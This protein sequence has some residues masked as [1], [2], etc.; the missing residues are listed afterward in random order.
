[1]AAVPTPAS[2]A[3]SAAAASTAAV[4]TGRG[5]GPARSIS[6]GVVTALVSLVYGLS[7]SA[8]LFSGELAYGLSRGIGSVLVG[9]AVTTLVVALFSSFRFAVAGPD[10]NA[11]AVSAGMLAVLGHELAASVPPDTAVVNVLYML[12]F[13]SC[14][15]GVCLYLLGLLRAGRWIRFV[16]Y[17]VIGGFIASAG[18]LMAVGALRV[19][20]GEQMSFANISI[21][22][23]PPVMYQVAAGVV[24]MIVLWAVLSRITHY[25]ALPVMLLAG[26]IACH[27]LLAAA[28]LDFA[29]ARAAGWLFSVSEGMEFWYPWN[30]SDLALIEWG[31]LGSHLGSM[32]TVVV[33]TTL[34]ILLNATGIELATHI[35][36][37]LD[38][39]LRVE[40]GANVA[41]A[42][43]GGFLGYLSFSRSMINYR[44]GADS[45]LAGVVVALA[46]FLFVLAGIW[47][48]SY[49]PKPILG[50]LLL[51]LGFALCYD[52]AVRSR[53]RI[54]RLD[55]LAILLIFLVILVWNFVS[56]VLVG[57]AVG[58]VMFVAN[59]SRVKVIKHS[60]S[61]AEYRSS[62]ER[63]QD[64][65][66]VLREHG[67]A[68][69]IFVLQSFIFFGMADRL[70]RA[71]MEQA[72]IE[73]AETPRFLVFDFRL[74]HGIDSS[75][76]TSFRKIAFAARAA[77]TRVVATGISAELGR[78][79]GADE[80]T[81]L[82]E[83]R[84]FPDLDRGVEWC[85]SE[86]IAAYPAAVPGED[87]DILPWLTREL[88]DAAQAQELAAY[89]RRRELAADEQLCRQDD[90]ADEM[91]FIERG[92][93]R[94]ELELPGGRRQR[95]RTLGRRTVLGEM[96]LYRDSS[97]S[98]SVYAEQASVVYSLSRESLERMQAE[99]P[100]LAA[101]FN[102]AIVRTL[103]NRLA[104]A[105]SL[106]AALQR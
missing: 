101:L 91:Y 14:V 7:F 40:G 75:A 61:G 44:M 98:A 12:A 30:A 38:R 31:V 16:P 93:V 92:R 28:G 3:V 52:W 39:E 90:A 79:F 10:S 85:E 97:R 23:Q 83:V 9:L 25:L 56:G 105:N 13:T 35:D 72:F 96:G 4:P 95:L 50:G 103:A 18:W 45:R 41:A 37:D 71:V 20:T 73:T 2:N 66:Q 5:A 43:C 55:H 65:L 26:T 78:E 87:E 32:G 102:A 59:Y 86:L 74:V 82:R 81:E 60:V 70:Y 80:A 54:S 104:F 48:V 69:R 34:T 47:M 58:C 88:G 11:A 57:V 100:A 33:V 29:E 76:V 77:G 106:V 24:W 21:L 19:I 6:G 67:E 42:I 68:I 15:T 63:S 51:Y 94:I 84:L 36:A 49:L 62:H 99:R 46:A 1:M 22:A 89:L 17:P 27:A 64:E 53:R 8:L